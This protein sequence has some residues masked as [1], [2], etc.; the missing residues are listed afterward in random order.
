MKKEKEVRKKE[1][2]KKKEERKKKGRKER[3]TKEKKKKESKNKKGININRENS[4]M[5]CQQ[6]SI[7]CQE[8]YYSRYVYLFK[9]I[10]YN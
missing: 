2:K 5:W 3:R 4:R 9:L 6:V 7:D 8:Y 1:R 10:R